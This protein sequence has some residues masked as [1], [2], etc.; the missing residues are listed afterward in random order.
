MLRDMMRV[1]VPEAARL[2]PVPEEPQ[3]Q[4]G[5]FARLFGRVA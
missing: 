4:R 2:L 3:P 5:F 1:S